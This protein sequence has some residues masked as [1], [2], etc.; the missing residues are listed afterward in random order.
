MGRFAAAWTRRGCRLRSMKYHAHIDLLP[1]QEASLLVLR[2]VN[3]SLCSCIL[4]LEFALVDF[5]NPGADLCEI[6]AQDCHECLQP[7]VQ[8]AMR[9]S[10]ANVFPYFSGAYKLE[11]KRTVLS[12]RIDQENGLLTLNLT[13]DMGNKMLDIQNDLEDL[14]I[15]LTKN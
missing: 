4:N 2:Q 7:L 11:M 15:G 14:E 5:L 6:G 12:Q 10:S 8:T 1:R 13:S 9:N 3:L